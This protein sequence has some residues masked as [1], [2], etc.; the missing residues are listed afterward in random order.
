ML[1]AISIHPTPVRACVT[2]GAAHIS[3]PCIEENAAAS[4]IRATNINSNP[5]AMTVI[6]ASTRIALNHLMLRPKGLP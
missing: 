2:S 1:L 3:F 6:A 4:S 5:T